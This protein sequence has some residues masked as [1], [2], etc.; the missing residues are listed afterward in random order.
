MR[1]RVLV[2]GM[3][4][5]GKSTVLEV[6]AERGHRVVDTDTD[7]W[8]RWVTLP[9]GSADWIWREDAMAALLDGHTDGALFVA[10]CKTNQ[11]A[12]YPRFEHVVL[13]SVPAEVILARI[14]TRT[15]NPYGQDPASRALIL[16]DLAE[17][18]PLL[19]A[20]ATTE[21]DATAPL[22]DVVGALEALVRD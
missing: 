21:L 5:T 14:A 11:G 2:T 20:T 3:S 10:G 1:S 19:R 8:C 17:V 22:D 18:E 16:R 6:L 7:E 15:T 13:L 4:G 9:D 12:F